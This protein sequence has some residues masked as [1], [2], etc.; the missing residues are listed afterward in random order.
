ML[1]KEPARLTDGYDV[2]CEREESRLTLERGVAMCGE[3]EVLGAARC[4][5]FRDLGGAGEQGLGW[6][7]LSGTGRGPGPERC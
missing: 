3:K 7:R 4:V 1:E 5:L 6:E 2:G